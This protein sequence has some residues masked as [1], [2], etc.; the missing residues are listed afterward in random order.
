MG[1]LNEVPN[2]G[3]LVLVQPLSGGIMTAGIITF[4]PSFLRYLDFVVDY[5]LVLIAGP[6]SSIKILHSS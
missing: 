6:V 3:L 2:S 1:F 4:F 5:V